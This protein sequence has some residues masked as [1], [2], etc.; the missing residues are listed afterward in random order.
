MSDSK[1]TQDSGSRATR[2]PA[3][4]GARWQAA[5]FRLSSELATAV[6][7]GDICNRVVNTLEDTLGYDFV[8]LLLLDEN[9]G[10]RNLVASV[11]YE[12]PP[13]PIK[14]GMGLSEGPLLTGELQYTPDVARLGLVGALRRLVEEE[15]GSAFDSVMW[16]IE[17]GVEEKVQT[18][19]SLTAEVLYYAAREA[20][21]N[22]ARHGRG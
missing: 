21:R 13:T 7:V 1:L 2:T 5:L 20:I 3:D 19:P 14:P 17:P 4:N 9:T 12:N 18:L 11:G 10:Y 16:Q 8:A 22:A 15:L 6:E